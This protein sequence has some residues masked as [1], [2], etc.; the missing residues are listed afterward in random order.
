MFSFGGR[1]IQLG[2][3][4][5]SLIDKF[6]RADGVDVRVEGLKFSADAGEV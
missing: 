2:T 5:K 3:A 6:R 1:A 4:S